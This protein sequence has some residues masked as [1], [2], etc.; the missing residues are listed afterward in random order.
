M[1]AR[2]KS[3][4]KAFFETG[5]FPSQSNFGDLIDSYINTS[6]AGTVGT[7]ILGCVTSASAA[8]IISGSLNLGTMAT[9]N[10][11]SISVSGG[12]LRGVV[13]SAATVSAS[14]LGTPTSIVLTNGTLLPL[15]TGVTGVLPEANGGTGSSVSR[16]ILGHD[17]TQTGAVSTGTTQIPV[18]DST[19]LITEGDQYLT[20]SYTPVS[21]NSTLVVE[22]Q[23]FISHSAATNL[24]A[25]LFV[26][27]VTSALSVAHTTQPTA[28]GVGHVSL[29]YEVSSNS[30]SARTYRIRAGGN[31][32]GTTTFNGSGG[33]R[34]FGGLYNSF[35]S[36]TEIAA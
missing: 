28:T 11:N 8:S 17:F 10:A 6:A 12:T 9:Q 27:A 2:S 7:Q 26:D 34:L 32:A 3:E 19:P 25:A 4:I 1:T 13:V 18:D 23:T 16:V 29:R 30:T 22:A 24:I 33:A 31:A 36:V 21:P 15:T 35:I 14:S 20:L 5:D